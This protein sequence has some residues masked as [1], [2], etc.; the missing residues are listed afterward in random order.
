MKA[1]FDTLIGRVTMYNLMVIV[2]GAIAVVALIESALGQI[3]YTPLEMILSLAVAIV[4]TAV[5]SWVFALAFRTRAHLPS[6]TI[7]GLL[8][9]FVFIPTADPTGLLLMALTAVVAAA[10]KFLLAIRGRHVLNPVA[11]AAVIMSVTALNPSGWWVATPVLLPVVVVGA[12]LVLYRTGRLAIGGTFVLLALVIVTARMVILGSSFGDALWLA[13]GSFPIVFLAGFML[14][15]PLT[16]PPRRGQQLLVAAVVAVLFSIPF[17]IGPVYSSPEIALVIGNIVAFFF[18]QRRGIRLRYVGSRQLTPTSTAFDFEPS[19]PVRFLPGQYLELALPHRGADSR[20]TRR[21]FSIT[22]A[23]DAP[24]RVSVG[25]KLSQPSSSFKKA[26]VGLTPGT[27][28]RSTWVGGDFLL[29]RDAS[30]P[31]L[32]AAGGIG[33]TPFVSQLAARSAGGTQP[34]DV[35]LVYAV[36]APDELAYADEL[37][38]AGIRVL[39]TAPTEPPALPSGWVYL[40]AARVTA[41]VLRAAVPDIDARR[42]YVS[43]PPGFVDHVSAELRHAGARGIRTDAFA[44]Y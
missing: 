13:V 6:S 26:L 12:F 31:V 18:G 39:V 40:G 15:E 2:L 35:V 3:F 44:G 23:P 19:H 1:R 32:L 38:A 8:I 11:A 7:T 37:A 14:S 34:V 33:I 22:S 30:H 10:S 41:D 24:D 25:I 43:G 9:F 17:S 21:M 5:A 29:P 42:A 27:T 16:L 4:V 36:S 20:G 28:V